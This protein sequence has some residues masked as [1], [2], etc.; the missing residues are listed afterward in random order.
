VFLQATVR[1][2]WLLTS[3]AVACASAPPPAPVAAPATP[4]VA[5]AGELPRSS[6][7]AILAHREEL[8]LTPDQ[9]TLLQ[10]RDDALAREDE[11]LRK[12]IAAGSQTPASSSA[13]GF[14]G[15]RGGH[16]GHHSAQRPPDQKRPP[17]PLTQLDDNDTRAFLEV[18]QQVLT[19]AQ[20]PRAEEIATRFREALYDQQHPGRVPHGADAD[21]GTAGR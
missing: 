5:P 20:H 8:G 14:Q 15:S 21:A 3:L 19:E 1:S 10:R 4:P 9:V 18:E 2:A 11:A 6:I 16:G 13:S 7:A 12:R 17:D